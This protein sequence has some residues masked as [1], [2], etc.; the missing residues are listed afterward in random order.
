[1]RTTHSNSRTRSLARRRCAVLA[2]ACAL[3]LVEQ[4]PLAHDGIAAQIAA[5]T[6]QIAASPA[7]ADLFV[8]RG[9]L[10]RA[11]RQWVQALADLDRAT[12]LD[13]ALAS[14]DLVRTTCSST[15]AIRDRPP[16]RRHGF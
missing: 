2:L 9:E 10:Y 14:A 3:F 13:P 11:T 8:K 7:S 1:L 5:L 4:F 16:T 12:R 15:S 6:A